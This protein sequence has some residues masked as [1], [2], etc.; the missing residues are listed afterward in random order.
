MYA[1]LVVSVSFLCVVNSHYAYVDNMM[2]VFVLLA[3]IFTLDIT[4]NPCLKNYFFPGQ[5][6]KDGKGD[7]EPLSLSS[8]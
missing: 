4:A 7:P 5:P 8:L 6:R 3:Y 2:L 1:C